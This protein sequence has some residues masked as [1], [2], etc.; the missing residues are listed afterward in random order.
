MIQIARVA[1]DYGIEWAYLPEVQ[2]KWQKDAAKSVGGHGPDS[3]SDY[4][5]ERYEAAFNETYKEANECG[6]LEVF[7]GTSKESLEQG[8]Y[9]VGL[10]DSG[11]KLLQKMS[12]QARP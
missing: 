11:G 3:Y 2:N 9:S 8:T 4:Q 1:Y 7:P 10:S 5:S 6:Y 12:K